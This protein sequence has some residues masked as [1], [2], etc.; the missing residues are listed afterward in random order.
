MALIL[1]MTLALRIVA[2]PV[3][4]AAPAPGLMAI[5][6][7]GQIVYVSMEDG[8]PVGEDAPSIACPFFSITSVVALAELSIAPPRS[9]I[10]TELSS[11]I[12]DVAPAS[13][14]RATDNQSRA[15]PLLG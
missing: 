1:A 12:G 4:M 15:P 10:V 2:A 6:T 13:L 11:T 7:G 8:Q 14:T 3:I 5:C 9:L